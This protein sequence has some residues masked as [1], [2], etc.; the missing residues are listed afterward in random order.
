[1]G[2]LFEVFNL[3]NSRIPVPL[4][5]YDSVASTV[6]NYYLVLTLRQEDLAISKHARIPHRCCMPSHLSILFSIHSHSHLQINRVA[7]GHSH[8][9]LDLDVLREREINNY[10]HPL[11]LVPTH[12]QPKRY[13][14]K[15]IGVQYHIVFDLDVLL[16]R[17]VELDIHVREVVILVVSSQPEGRIHVYYYFRPLQCVGSHYRFSEVDVGGNCGISRY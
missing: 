13:V 4:I 8:V 7:G 14:R 17:D 16:K 6:F 12:F 9:V 2:G 11:I 1:M 15:A 5:I 3:E 10:I